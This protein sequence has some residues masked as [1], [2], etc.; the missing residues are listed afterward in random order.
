MFLKLFNHQIQT[1]CFFFF[2]FYGMYWQFII[3]VYGLRCN[4]KFYSP[5]LQYPYLIKTDKYIKFSHLSFK[6][7]INASIFR[8]DRVFPKT[9]TTVTEMPIAFLSL[10][11]FQHFEAKC[12]LHESCRRMNEACSQWL[13]TPAASSYVCCGYKWRLFLPRR[14]LWHGHVFSIGCCLVGQLTLVITASAAQNLQVAFCLIQATCELSNIRFVE[15]PA[16]A[17]VEIP[18]KMHS[19]SNL[20]L[21]N[22]A[23]G[24]FSNRLF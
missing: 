14:D 20:Q 24:I 13:S 1:N 4:H 15:S 17:G 12:Y 2:F 10:A 16:F 6:Y 8:C 18:S 3:F 9:L 23:H 22:N 19:G 21:T 11:Y 5:Y 7:F